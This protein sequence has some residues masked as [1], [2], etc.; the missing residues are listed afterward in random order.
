[1]PGQVEECRVLEI[2]RG[3]QE[4]DEGPINVNLRVIRFVMFCHYGSGLDVQGLGNDSLGVRDGSMQECGDRGSLGASGDQG[5][6]IRVS[7][8]GV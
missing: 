6:G 2:W 7:S 4:Y 1:M 8:F 3:P 5:F